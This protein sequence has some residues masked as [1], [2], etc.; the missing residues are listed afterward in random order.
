MTM[1]NLPNRDRTRN[2]ATVRAQRR[3]ERVVTNGG[4]RLEIL[5]DAEAAKALERQMAATGETARA[6]VFRLLAQADQL[7][8]PR[9]A[10]QEAA[11]IIDH[12]GV[13]LMAE[14]FQLMGKPSS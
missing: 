9:M 10:T 13:P 3:L 5:L 8:G 12:N 7:S 2:Q 1:V 11:E 14:P 4:R 6:V